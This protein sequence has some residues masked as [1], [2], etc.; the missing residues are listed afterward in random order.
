MHWFHTSSGSDRSYSDRISALLELD[1]CCLNFLGNV[2]F[3]I[4]SVC[5]AVTIFVPKCQVIQCEQPVSCELSKHYCSIIASHIITL[6]MY[7]PNHV[8]L[9]VKRVANYETYVD[10]L[11]A[12]GATIVSAAEHSHLMKEIHKI[13]QVSIQ[14]LLGLERIHQVTNTIRFANTGWRIR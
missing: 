4:N 14:Y 10:E 13:R 9:Q 8:C 11:L 1:R 7:S 5:T 6:P 3:G 12:E 2:G